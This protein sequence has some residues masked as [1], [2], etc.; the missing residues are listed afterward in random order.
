MSGQANNLQFFLPLLDR[1]LMEGI[2]VFTEDGERIGSS[3][4]AAKKGIT[5]VVFS[6]IIMATP[7]MGKSSGYQSEHS[8]YGSSIFIDTQ[9]FTGVFS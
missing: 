1:E 7:G 4:T 9:F 5:Q 8:E 3:K 6:R 2:P